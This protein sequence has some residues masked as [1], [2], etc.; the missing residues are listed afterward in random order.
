MI[1]KCKR[2]GSN[3]NTFSKMRKWCTDCRK[4]VA[5]EQA[6]ARKF[7]VP[8]EDLLEKLIENKL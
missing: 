4:R 5:V 1:V 8:Y 2:C 6:K 3:I 7:D